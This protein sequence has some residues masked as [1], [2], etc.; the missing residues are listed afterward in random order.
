MFTLQETV[1]AL[2]ATHDIPASDIRLESGS[3]SAEARVSGLIEIAAAIN[4]TLNFK[5]LLK[6]LAQK[7]AQV[8]GVDRCSIFLN[9][10]GS[11]APAMSQFASGL[12][13]PDLWAAFKALG[14]YRL[15][16]VRAFAQTLE[17]RQ[18]ILVKDP[19]ATGLVPRHWVDTFGLRSVLVFPLL[20]QDRVVG[21]LHLDNCLDATPITEA[22]AR[23][24]GA[25]A[26]QL[27][28]AIDN[29]HL[30]EERQSRLEM[31]ETLLEVGRTI[32]SSLELGEVARRIA[33]EAARAIG[34]DSTGIFLK[35]EDERLFQPFAGYHVPKSFLQSIQG[36][37][38]PVV[39]FRQLQRL[40][41]EQSR[42]VWSD[43]V[44]N[45]PNFSH[46]L[47]RRLGMRS[48]LLTRLHTRGQSVGVLSCMWQTGRPR[49]TPEKVRL[50]EGIADQAALAI[51]NAR[52]YEKAEEL[53]V[54]RERIRVAAGLHD[55]LSQTLFSVVLKLDWCLHHASRA[56]GLRAKLKEIKRD[57]AFIML[58]L[59]TLIYQISPKHGAG[60]HAER[61]RKLVENFKEFG[62]LPLEFTERGDLGRL[63]QAQGDAL[64]N[65]LQ[66]ALANVVKHAR[67]TRVA[68]RVDV[69]GEAVLF[70][71]VDDGIGM[72][73]PGPGEDAGHLGLRLIA[74]RVAAVG[75]R[76]EFHRNVPSGLRVQGAIPGL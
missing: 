39:E 73:P 33:R 5:T 20:R 42:S 34:A 4:S 62:S 11:L 52:L 9:R 55:A 63:G 74:D 68:M 48:I 6:I 26:D 36:E 2:P 61:L 46:E 18:P 43:D 30:V 69:S 38:L 32:G 64:V 14:P 57:A 41:N 3:T 60:H 28:L 31:T 10:G 22:Q 45:D 7:T 71:V 12:P 23:L 44:P 72:P 51:V 35:T 19:L 50:I 15:E 58:Q 21:T 59:R 25:I 54:S 16:E 49:F 75:G 8:C 47:F 53:A 1:D 56:R 13:H 70:E 65:V 67:A 66:E 76:V 37:R 27:A 29:A 24:A 17:Q 40:L